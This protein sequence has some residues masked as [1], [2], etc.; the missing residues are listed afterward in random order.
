[1]SVSGKQYENTTQMSKILPASNIYRVGDYVFVETQ[2]SLPYQIRR[3]EELTKTTNGQVEAKVS[4]FYRR[5]DLSNALATQADKHA[6]SAEEE[7]EIDVGTNNLSDEQ[8]HQLKHREVF[9][10]RQLEIINANTIR[11][12]CSVT[13]YSEVEKLIDYLYEDDWFYYLLVYDPQQK[14]LLADR[15]EIGVGEEYQADFF[16]SFPLIKKD[17]NR[18]SP[19]F[20]DDRDLSE[21]ETMQWTPDNPL[22]DKQVDQYLV[23]ARS[24]GTFARA[25]DSGSSVKEPSLHLTAAAAS[26]DIT[27]LSALLMLHKNDYDI[28][29]AVSALI[30]DGGPILCRDEMEEWSSG[31][32][33]LFEE[34]IRKHGKEFIEIQQEYLPWKSI[35]NIVE[36]YYM[37]K[38]TDK[39]VQQKRLKAQEG[40][41]KVTQIF[42]PSSNTAI[43]LTLAIQASSQYQVNS[44]GALVTPSYMCESCFTKE[45]VLW[46]PWGQSSSQCK[47]YLCKECWVYWKKCGGLKKSTKSTE[48]SSE[49]E[50]V[51]KCRICNKKFNRAERLSSHMTTHRGYDCSEDGCGKTFTLKA[52]LTRHLAKSHCI[53]PLDSKMKVKTP[54]VMTST[55]FM[56]VARYLCKDKLRL[57]HFARTPTDMIDLMEIKE[58]ASSKINSENAKIIFECVK[59]YNPKPLD[60]IVLNV[61][62][63]PKPSSLKLISTS[64]TKDCSPEQRNSPVGRVS[65]P[66][67]QHVATSITQNLKAKTLK[68]PTPIMSGSHKRSADSDQNDYPSTKRQQPMQSASSPLGRKGFECSICGKV[69]H[70][71]MSLQHHIQAHHERN[72]PQ[73]H[74]PQTDP[75]KRS[76]QHYHDMPP[77]AAHN[78]YQPFHSTSSYSHK[79]S[80]GSLVSHKPRLPVGATSRKQ[81]YK[82]IQNRRDPD[83]QYVDPPQEFLFNASKDSKKARRSL[84][85]KA[86]RKIARKPFVQ[87]K[88]SQELHDAIV[89]KRS[90]D[91]RAKSADPIVIDDD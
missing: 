36:Y 88:C 53:F 91:I 23:V 73:I 30:P 85:S 29:K 81:S 50:A 65:S 3:I 78:Q 33:A 80:N 15:G 27:L 75:H 28:G 4:C 59:K 48:A 25:L 51:Y 39:Y 84:P 87:I 14:T 13:L 58:D 64:I 7:N 66:S 44:V 52:H 6:L 82:G 72:G 74:I 16:T 89:C 35:S 60:E 19:S 71:Q 38:T 46:Y 57:H 21:L 70:N 62:K 79:D 17:R 8:H 49:N 68:S 56:K 34:G 9:L 10:S 47:L 31:E 5:R 76:F 86:Q 20:E 54:F 77:P 90:S 43:N 69:L 67:F 55:P 45:S 1:M 26:R 63:K 32:A 40:D 61:K 2:P 41:S 24:I 22:T 11:G 12:K 18:S 83:M 42:I 37:W